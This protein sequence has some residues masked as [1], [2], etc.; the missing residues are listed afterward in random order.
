M[1]GLALILFGVSI[2]GLVALCVL[3]AIGDML[4][5]VVP[6]IKNRQLEREEIRQLEHQIRM[7]A[8]RRQSGI[9]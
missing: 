4:K 7:R 8:L 5:L 3:W 1:L 2:L 9:L 6:S